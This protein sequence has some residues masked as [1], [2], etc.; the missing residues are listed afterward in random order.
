MHFLILQISHQMQWIIQALSE[1]R[2]QLALTQTDGEEIKNE[3]NSHHTAVEQGFRDA[4]K[5]VTDLSKVV[6]G[7][8][9]GLSAGALG[10][11]QLQPQVPSLQPPQPPAPQIG[12]SRIKMAKPDKFDGTKG[13]KVVDLRISCSLFLRTVHATA[14]PEQQINF[15]M[16]YLEE[17]AQQ[18]LW[19]HLDN[20]IIQNIQIPWL[21]DVAL[22]WQ[23]FDKRFGEIN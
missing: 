8:Q 20:E 10:V 17:T 18:W 5:A 13:E 7:L 22:F 12:T 23:E 9:A 11:P 2:E 4:A 6:L 3:A 19:P 16:S 21:H 15:I 14:M 1:L